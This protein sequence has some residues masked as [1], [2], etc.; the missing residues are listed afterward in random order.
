VYVLMSHNVP[1]APQKHQ[2]RIEVLIDLL[3]EAMAEDKMIVQLY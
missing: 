2:I 1:V 3:D